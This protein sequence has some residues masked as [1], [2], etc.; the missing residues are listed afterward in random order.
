MFAGRWGGG[1]VGGLGLV[2]VGLV[3]VSCL[4]CAVFASPQVAVLSYKRKY[5][6]KRVARFYL[7]DFTRLL[8]QRGSGDRSSSHGGGR[9]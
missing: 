1:G 7:V 4:I 8:P 5:R 2:L 6:A 9:G 3:S